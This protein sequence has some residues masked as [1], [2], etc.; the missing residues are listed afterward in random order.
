MKKSFLL[1]IHLCFIS[2]VV[3]TQEETL[4]DY[5]IKP[6]TP[7]WK[8]LKTKKQMVDACQIPLDILNNLSTKDLVT[9]SLNYP[10][11][12][13]YL[14]YDDER[15]GICMIIRRFN[16]LKELSQRE[17]GITE[18]IKAYLN[19][20]ILDQLQKD[21]NHKDYH[22]PYKLPFLELVLCDD[23]FLNKLDDE[24]LEE[25]RKITLKKY[26]DKLKN[27]DVYSTLFNL[28]KT[29][30]LTVSI[31]YRQ[32]IQTLSQE[33]KDSISFFIKG[34]KNCSYDLLTEISKIITL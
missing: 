10:L 23:L 4:W 12:N 34:Y 7:E 25:L 32:N 31:I 22:T 27:P 19:F 30:L 1:F 11:F 16:G 14:E 29:M 13:D 2:F 26:T 8:T 6:G 17:D 5:P 3:F 21:P 18:I 15:M 28:K 20:P 24:K 33:Q 9:I